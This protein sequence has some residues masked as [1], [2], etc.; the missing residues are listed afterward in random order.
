MSSSLQGFL[1]LTDISR[2]TTYLEQSELEHARDTLAALMEVL[3]DRTRPPF[4]ISK[5]EGD[6]VLSYAPTDALLR[7]QTVMEMVDDIYVGFRQGIE[8]MVLNNTCRCNACANVSSLDLKLFLHHGTF[9]MQQV[10]GR[11]E[12]F[13]NDVVLAHRLLKNDIREALGVEAY[14][15]CTE[16]AVARLGSQM[17]EAMISHVLRYDDVGEVDVWVQDMHPV[18]ESRRE[19]DVVT[20]GPSEVL[21]EVS[22]Y[23]AMP[24]ELVW[25]YLADPGFRTILAG[26]DR[27]ELSKL[28]SGKIA[29]GTVFQCFHGNT[30][31]PQE[32][33]E[34]RP[35]QRLVTRD[36]LPLPGGRTFGLSFAELHPE[37]SG[38]RLTQRV[39]GLAGPWPMRLAASMIIRRMQSAAVRNIEA[40]RDAIERDL[41]DRLEPRPVGRF[42]TGDAGWSG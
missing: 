19:D 7:G 26:S 4:T 17:K 29:P 38:T 34:W 31:I 41:R 24:P 12:L 22:T 35:F 11:T 14:T 13:G 1:F 40:F 28:K 6:A 42:G 10:G 39:G 9:A 2:Y 21:L 30:V 16:A 8:R 5:L 15:A 23:I 3:I 18:W 36:R 32:V 25:D 27:Q 33:I 37:G 20:L